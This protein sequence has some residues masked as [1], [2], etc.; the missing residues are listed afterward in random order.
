MYRRYS[1]TDRNCLHQVTSSTR[2]KEKLLYFL[3]SK[4]A[5]NKRMTNSPAEPVIFYLC[6]SL[7]FLLPCM[8]FP[9][10]PEKFPW[11]IPVSKKTK[12]SNKLVRGVTGYRTNCY[13]YVC[14]HNGIK[15]SLNACAPKHSLS[16]G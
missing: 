10:F 4:L 5:Q 12:I 15:R 16:Y 8:R 14:K 13:G 7:C 6:K 2:V 9:W 3:L 11:I 1:V